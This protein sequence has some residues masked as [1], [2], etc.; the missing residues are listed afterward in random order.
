MTQKNKKGLQKKKKKSIFER[1]F[2]MA[3]EECAINK[4]DETFYCHHDEEIVEDEEEI[5]T[6]IHQYDDENTGTEV[7][8]SQIVELETPLESSSSHNG[9]TSGSSD[10]VKPK[11]LSDEFSNDD[12]D[13]DGEF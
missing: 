1:Y 10:G 12:E 4:R 9:L 13:D 11:R 7:S 2:A 5:V 6:E 3:D 8:I